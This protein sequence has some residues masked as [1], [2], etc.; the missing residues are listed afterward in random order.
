MFISIVNIPRK[1]GR[2]DLVIS[3]CKK[4]GMSFTLILIKG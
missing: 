2:M 3:Q 1:G 4:N